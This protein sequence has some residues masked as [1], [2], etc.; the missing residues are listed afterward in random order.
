MSVF[1]QILI[2]IFDQLSKLISI[3]NKLERNMYKI[4]RIIPTSIAADDF[5]EA[6]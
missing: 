5:G 2:L 3:S 1:G 6:A 4:A